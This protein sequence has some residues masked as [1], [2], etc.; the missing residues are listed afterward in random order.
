[1]KLHQLQSLTNE[2]ILVLNASDSFDAELAQL[3][4]ITIVHSASSKSTARLPIG[5]A[6]KQ[7][8]LDQIS[9]KFAK[10][11]FGNAIVWVAYPKQ[12]SKRYKCEFNRDTVWN[13][14]GNAGVE[15][16]RQ[17]AIDDDW[18]ALRFRRTKQVAGS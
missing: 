11:F 5:F 10:L 3:T 15:P 12:A 17:I 14:L 6:I 13:V 4:G 16:V 1:M 18:S 9:A 2:T 8:K 7:V